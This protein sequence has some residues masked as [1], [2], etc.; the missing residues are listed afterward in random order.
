MDHPAAVVLAVLLVEGVLDADPLGQQPPLVEVLGDHPD[1]GVVDLAEL[2][3]RLDRL[4]GRLLRRIHRVV[5]LALGLG[6]RP[7][8]RQGAG[9]VGGEQRVD[10]D[11][12]VEEQHLAVLEVA[13][14]LDPVQRGGVVPAGA[15]RVVPDAVALVAGVEAE[16]ALDPALAAALGDR[17]AQLGD[18]RLEPLVGRGDGEPHLLDLPLVLDQPQRGE[19]RRPAR[20]RPPPALWTAS[21]SAAFS[22]AAARAWST[23]A[24]TLEV[25]VAHDAHGD[26][27]GVLGRRRRRTRRCGVRSARTRP[28]CRPGSG[29]APDPELAV[30]GV[31]EELVGVAA[32]AAA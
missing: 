6:E 32:G 30:A 7:V 31:A 16:D 21:A 20:R 27:A 10:L 3:P 22:D 14:V 5:D 1:G 23:C 13:G 25:G 12:R 11:A 26:L 4:H 8:D 18:D 15:D 9:D 17:V 28:R 24:V 19:E 2:D 29:G